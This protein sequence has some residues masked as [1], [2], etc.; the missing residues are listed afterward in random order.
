MRD[1][2]FRI[3]ADLADGGMAFENKAILADDCHRHIH[4]AHVIETEAPVEQAQKRP[5][6]AGCVVVLRLRKQKR[7]SSFEISKVDIVS[8]RRADDIAAARYDEHDFGF[9]VVPA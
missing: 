2:I 8:E 9:G 7:G 4:L 1:E 3:P 5:D 6:R